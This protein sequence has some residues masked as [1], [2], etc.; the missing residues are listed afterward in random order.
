MTKSW[1]DEVPYS[2][3]ETPLPQMQID[4]PEKFSHQC[5]FVK[6]KERHRVKASRSVVNS[7]DRHCRIRKVKLK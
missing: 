4:A 2:G 1:W 7:Q 6:L 5:G 3:G